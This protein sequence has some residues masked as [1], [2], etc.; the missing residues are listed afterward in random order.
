MQSGRYNQKSEGVLC[1]FSAVV[2]INNCCSAE[3][4]AFSNMPLTTVRVCAYCLYNKYW[5]VS[6][7][8]AQYEYTA[9]FCHTWCVYVCDMRR[10]CVDGR[11]DWLSS[12]Q[13]C[14]V[15]T[16][17]CDC[18]Q[19]RARLGFVPGLILLSYV[20]ICTL[21]IPYAVRRVLVYNLSV[22][23]DELDGYG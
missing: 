9:R 2:S 8:V 23:M 7:C 6:L 19:Q 12:W 14:V 17:T 13:F 1:D 5:H 20:P 4:T 15:C 10:V 16:P 11:T 3:Y 18:K 22:T 21:W